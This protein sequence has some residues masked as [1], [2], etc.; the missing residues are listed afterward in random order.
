MGLIVNPERVRVLRMVHHWSQE[1][2]ATAAGLGI[3]TIQRAEADGEVSVA[4]AKA[5]AAVFET[6]VED[7]STTQPSADAQ[8]RP[9]FPG[10]VLGVVCAFAA[11]ALGVLGAANYSL[12]AIGDAIGTDP[13]GPIM[14][15]SG[16]VLGA[17]SA[18]VGA[19]IGDRRRGSA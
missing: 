7:L 3:R 6:S 13:T 10:V 9:Q 1:E 17:V 14:G 5:L 15:L 4:T 12:D 19:W 18:M 2:L 8:T 11:T 16:A